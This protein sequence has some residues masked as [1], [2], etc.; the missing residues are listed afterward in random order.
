MLERLCVHRK[1][2]MS[3]S[4][5]EIPPVSK[6]PQDCNGTA[7]RE[8][9]SSI[10]ESALSEGVGKQKG[11]MTR[12]SVAEQP[13]ISFLCYAGFCCFWRGFASTTMLE[14]RRKKDAKQDDHDDVEH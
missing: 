5:S 2:G 3:Q 10:I 9:D 7:S 4:C 13:T 6:A 12:G 11:H 8:Q 14:A 1:Q